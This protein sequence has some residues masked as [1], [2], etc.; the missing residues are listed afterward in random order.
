MKNVLPS[1][2]LK[3]L[4]FTQ[5]VIN[6]GG[7][8]WA[9]GGYLRDFYLNKESK[10]I[11]VMVTGVPKDNLVS[12]LNKYGTH[13]LVGESFGIIK[14]KE[15]GSDEEI[16]VSLPRKDVKNGSR[17][18]RAFDVSTDPFMPVDQELSRRDL[19]LN[20]MAMDVYGNV[21]DPFGGL[22]DIKNRT[23]NVTNPETFFDDPLRM[24]RTI[25]FSARFNFEVSSETMNLI[26]A[27]AWL[28]TSIS[29]ERVLIELEKIVS[30]GKPAIGAKLLLD[31][32]LYQHIF[33]SNT[34][35]LS[36]FPYVKDLAEFIYLLTNCSLNADKFFKD[37]LKGDI[38]NTKEIGAIIYVDHSNGTAPQM[39]LTIF[40][41][42]QKSERVLDCN[43]LES[44]QKQIVTEF[45][46]GKYPK[47]LKELAVD[48]NDVMS[49]G[50]QNAA[51]GE[52]ISRILYLI[53]EDKLK[54]DHKTI[55]DFL[56]KEKFNKLK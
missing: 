25:M 39:R 32:G 40:K 46:T 15:F 52:T 21:V 50:Y 12:I 9:V 53:F 5:D 7:M 22:N 56:L 2:M 24:L 20:S 6:Q 1:L 29:P 17:G 45:K 44:R 34:L 30:K 19:S 37:N 38:D 55:M 41:A 13:S 18:H 28:I 16:D 35:N 33:K 27:N 23:I 11:D 47:S 3:E 26:K 54:N 49:L 14:F 31:T 4:P 43:I 10:D 36:R 8:V 48:G 51:I 42:I